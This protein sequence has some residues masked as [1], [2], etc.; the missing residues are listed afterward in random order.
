VLAPWRAATAQVFN[1]LAAPVDVS[2]G[3]TG[4]RDVDVSAW[5]PAG[6]TGVILQDVNPTA[7][8]YQYA[9]RNNG[10]SDTWMLTTE[11]SRHESLG[12]HMIGVDAN[13]V[14]E[15]YHESTSLKTYLLGYTM[16]G[17]TFFVNA[18]DKSI[19]AAGSWT[20]VDISADTG[21]DTAI[22]AVF[23]VMDTTRDDYQVGL[24]MKGSSDELYCEKD[25]GDADTALIGLDANEVAQMKIENTAID[26]YL[27]GYVTSGA[28]FFTNAV[29]KATSTTG[30]YV[31]V[32][33]TGD[34]G[35]DDANGA[36]LRLVSSGEVYFGVRPNGATHDF[37]QRLVEQKWPVIGIDENN[38]LEQKISATTHDL[39][40]T[41]YT[42][43]TG[44]PI[45]QMATGTYTG[46]G[47]D[48]RSIAGVGFQP[49]VVIIKGNVAEQVVIRTSTMSGD[50][51]KTLNA[52]TAFTPDW[53]QSLDADG[54][55]VGTDARVNQSGIDYYWVAFSA[56]SGEMNV[57]SYVGDGSAGHTING[58]GFQPDYVIAFGEP[59][60][61]PWQRSSSMPANESIRFSANAPATNVI[62]GFVPDGFT[63]GNHAA[64]NSSGVQYHYAA[65]KATA[66]KMAVGSYSGD[67]IDD[68][69]IGGVGFQPEF[70]ITKIAVGQPAAMR[71]ES[72]VGDATLSATAVVNFADGIQ[73]LEAD[74]FQLGQHAQVNTASSTYYWMAF[75]DGVDAGGGG[76]SPHVE[77]FETWQAT[78]PAAWEVKDLS[79]APFNVPADAIAEIAVVNRA[80]GSA[81]WGG[82]RAVG[83][84]LERRFQLHEAEGGGTDVVVMHVQA[85]S[86]SQIEHYGETTTDVEF[87]LLGYWTCGTYT[88][89]FQTFKAGAS[90]SWRDHDLGPYGV[91][92]DGVAEVVLVNNSATGEQQAGVRANASGLSRLLDLH[93]AEGGGDDL[94]TL[95]V[96]ADATANATVEVYAENDINVDFYLV[97][98]WDDPPGPYTELAGDIGSPSADATWEDQDLS[99]YGVP[100]DAVA[101]IVVGNTFASAQNNMG[102]RE[103]ATSLA[104]LLDLQEAESGGGDY[105]RMHVVADGSSTIDFY[106]EDVSETHKFWLMGYWEPESVLGLADHDAGQE[107]DAFTES[108]VQIAAELF[109]FKL[110]PCGGTTTVTEVV[111]SLSSISGLTDLDWANVEVVVDGNGDGDINGGEGTTVGG[112]GVVDQAAGT[113]TFSGGFAVTAATDYILRADFVTL[114]T[115]DMVTISLNDAD[116]TPATSSVVGVTS[117]VTHREGAF[118][119][120]RSQ[121]WQAAVAGSWAV[122]D[123]SVAPFKIPANAVVEVAV[124]NTNVGTER[125]GGVRAVGSSLERRFLLHEA[126]DGGRDV[127]VMH[128]QTDG[129]SQIEHYAGNL[130]DIQFTLLGY[131]DSGTYIERFQSL[132]ATTAATWE[133]LDLSLYGVGPDQVAEF[134]LV[135]T[136]AINEYEAGVRKN[137]SWPERRIDLHEAEEGGVDVATMLVQADWTADATVEV[138]A[139]DEFAVDF[140]LVGYWSTP[141]RPYKQMFVD[142][143]SPSTDG[144]WEDVDLSS[145]DVPADA[146]V[147]ML[148]ANRQVTEENNMGVRTNGSSLLRRLQ[149]QEAEDGGGDLGRM[150]VAVG[151][152]TTIELYHEDVS[153]PHS[154]FLTGYWGDVI[155]TPKVV[156]WKET[157]P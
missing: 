2:P 121:T 15:V 144:T 96:Q 31:D 4:W 74:G 1:Y 49:D 104:R 21:A 45:A 102:V 9:V 37:Y 32:D 127:A 81:R 19:S 79:G 88:E 65:W 12:F 25:K 114:S 84:G 43:A 53:I 145:L 73:T 134:V 16:E 97:G 87:I 92:P 130:V 109:G 23:V 94:A 80:T 59:V 48:D 105:A 148:L 108:G 38:I 110:E 40:L 129:N 29:N 36:I 95:F 8:R 113:I 119:F 152:A 26:L 6:A 100:A 33:I 154:F 67:G 138:Y 72:L 63:L 147:E 27:V 75:S 141:P 55:T 135:N 35:S 86:S 58:V 42:L 156:T 85:D 136:N 56:G 41:G 120:E 125:S 122:Q 126:E 76:S 64:V 47:L 18:V 107:A 116:I 10:S 123:L 24:R 22:G 3:S 17:V 62:T 153:D 57:G 50:V 5:V 149:L 61:P 13:R 93:E 155:N 77:S 28:V 151:A 34:I 66:D 139:E 111:F 70:V 131:W 71:T 118:Y 78:S 83:S 51:S 99:S 142:I 101:E 30:S 98:Y 54:F 44:G 14:F 89:A 52:G 117:S 11:S 150:H 124:S 39:Y 112:A 132:S 91:G 157:E 143:G 7:T 103:N 140:Y 115:G 137:G 133:D 146:I 82:V 106:H 69:S 20:D 60:M 90:V 68:R 128:V 46:D